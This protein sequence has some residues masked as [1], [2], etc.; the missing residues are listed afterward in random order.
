MGKT[1]SA[2]D[3]YEEMRRNFSIEIPEYFNFGFDVIDQL[4]E[5]GPEQTRHDLGGPER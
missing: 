1:G 3:S 2:C 4:G 5:E